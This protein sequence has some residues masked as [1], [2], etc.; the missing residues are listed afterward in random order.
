MLLQKTFEHFSSNF[1]KRRAGKFVLDNEARIIVITGNKGQ[2]KT[3]ILNEFSRRIDENHLISIEVQPEYKEIPFLTV[4]KIFEWM[5]GFRKDMHSEEKQMKLRYILG[6]LE[7]SDYLCSLNSIF[8][9]NFEE[10]ETFKMSPSHE[11]YIVLEHMLKRLGYECFNYPHVLVMD[12]ADSIDSHSCGILFELIEARICFL[13][14]TISRNCHLN[15]EAE[16]LMK[17]KDRI[18]I[19]LENL[20]HIDQIALVCQILHVHA[21]PCEL[22]RIIEKNGEGNPGKIE[23]ILF[24]MLENNELILKLMSR[25][26]I[27]EMN[28]IVPPMHL[29]QRS[30]V[31]D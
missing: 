18:Q 5:L 14:V 22:E 24:K 13:I 16:G 7:L 29:I 9:T 4:R 12:A 19:D 25:E 15:L 21:I 1:K 17:H 30:M 28:L 27:K 20:Q 8:G 11:K 2:G 31:R 26:K 6:N 10:T 23:D 3:K